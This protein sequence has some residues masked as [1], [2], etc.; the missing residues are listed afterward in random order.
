MIFIHIV[1]ARYVVHVFVS[2]KSLGIFF[3]LLETLQFVQFPLP[4]PNN[5]VFVIW[6]SSQVILS[7][8]VKGNFSGQLLAVVNLQLSW[9]AQTFFISMISLNCFIYLCPI[10]FLLLPHGLPVL[11]IISNHYFVFSSQSQYSMKQFCVW[12]YANTVTL[13]SGPDYWIKKLATTCCLECLL[14]FL[15]HQGSLLCINISITDRKTTPS[16]FTI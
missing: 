9:I 3:P 14:Q 15:Q 5:D 16:I 8:F 1:I 12:E 10:R 2:I 13:C 4:P 7:C 6:P 11:F